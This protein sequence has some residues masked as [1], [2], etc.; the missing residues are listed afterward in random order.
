MSTK[1]TEPPPGV[2][3]G[4]LTWFAELWFARQSG[5]PDRE[6][7]ARRQLR[8]L[9]VDVLIDPKQPVG[10]TPAGATAKGAR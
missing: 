9:G 6:A 7:T 1:R 5:D 10:A 4:P 2:E 8:N 3:V